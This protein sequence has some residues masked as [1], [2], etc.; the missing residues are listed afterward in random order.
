VQ[1]EGPHN[2]GLQ[3]KILQKYQH[4]TSPTW[5]PYYKSTAF[6]TQIFRDLLILATHEEF[7]RKVAQHDRQIAA[8][9]EHVKTLL[10]PP[11][12]PKKP[13]IGFMHPKD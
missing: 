5:L 6:P 7:A 12:A 2:R 3:N 1:F 8:L 10:E 13:P 11:P 9:F 4:P